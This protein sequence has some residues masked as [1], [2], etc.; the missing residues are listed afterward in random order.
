MIILEI[1]ITV[2]RN[3]QDTQSNI[4]VIGNDNEVNWIK[5]RLS[6]NVVEFINMMRDIMNKGNGNSIM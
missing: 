1:K 4:I 6:D 5:F 2:V 3:I